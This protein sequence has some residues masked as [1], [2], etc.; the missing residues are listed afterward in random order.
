MHFC[1]NGCKT[2][3][4]IL[5][6]DPAFEQK[7]ITFPEI[8]KFEYL[9]K[10]D[11]AKY[12]ITFSQPGLN[13]ARFKL[14]AIHC[15]SCIQIL[16]RLQYLHSG[17]ISSR[18]DFPKKELTISYYSE[19]INLKE[20]AELL[21]FVGYEPE[22]NLAALSGDEVSG[23][24]KKLVLQI[25]VAGFVFGNVMLLSFPEYFGLKDPLFE[26]VFGYLSIALCIPLLTFSAS[27]Y[28]RSAHTSILNRSLNIDVPISLGILTLFLRSTYDIISHSGGG[29]LDSLSGFVFFLLIGKWFQQKTYDKISFER[30]YESYFPLCATKVIDGTTDPVLLRDIV[31][32]DNLLI[33]SKEIVPCDGVFTAEQGTI[34]YSFVS[35]ESRPISV[36]RDLKIFAGGRNIGSS[37]TIQVSNAVDQS[38]LTQL[39]EEGQ[40]DEK[41]NNTRSEITD[42]VGRYFT[43]TILAISILTLTYWLAIDS[44]VAMHAFTS[45]L[46]IAC[47]CVIALSIPFTYGSF[48]SMMTKL[49]VFIRNTETLEKIQSCDTIIF[50]KTGTLTTGKKAL[51]R[52]EGRTLNYQEKTAISQLCQQSSHPLSLHLFDHLNMGISK[53]VMEHFEESTGQGLKGLVSGLLVEIGSAKYIKPLGSNGRNDYGSVHIK[54]SG[55]Y[56]G[57]FQ[58]E[59]QF[60]PGL[61]AILSRLRSKYKIWLLSGDHN[62]QEDELKAVFGFDTSAM[63]FEQS[64]KDKMAFIKNLQRH[65]HKVIMIGD[66]L[67]DSGAFIQSDVGIVLTED[68]NN[69]T[70]ASDIVLQASAFTFLDK[71][72]ERVHNMKSILYVIY[73]MAL[74]YNSVGLFFAVQGLLSPIVAAILMPASSVSIVVLGYLLTRI[75]YTQLSFDVKH[76]NN[77]QIIDLPK[78][79]SVV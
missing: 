18:V 19:V 70:P 39:W 40:L 14:P 23:Y 47:P 54:I 26:R 10:D 6:N 22:I 72:L 46:I 55:E 62:T 48:L 69:F 79:L 63:Q 20:V 4:Q 29:Y 27:D 78:K 61:Q 75:Q 64:P 43:L 31:P 66:G 42:R 3:F 50:D 76:K 35:G 25:G 57:Y 37:F 52:Y 44:S 65:G 5:S 36:E 73:F 68:L 74:I 38:Y 77:E 67:N 30:N 21:T 13:K 41:R 1:C 51:V 60:R 71:I 24:N 58:I 32:G 17:I 16:E 45:V 53:Q 33:R 7:N 56:R 12:F 8:N 11:I 9:L 59:T 15:S 28:L 49:N 2:V 34:D